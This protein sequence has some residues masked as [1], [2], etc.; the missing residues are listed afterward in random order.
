MEMTEAFKYIEELARNIRD[1]VGDYQ[2]RIEYYFLALLMFANEEPVGMTFKNG[3][4]NQIKRHLEDVCK[5]NLKETEVLL[6]EKIKA[7]DNFLGFTGI[8][9]HMYIAKKY[10]CE[11]YQDEVA[12]FHLLGAILHEPPVYI[13]EFLKKKEDT[14]KLTPEEMQALLELLNRR[15]HK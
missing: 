2:E 3:E 9:R 5:K 10:A 8:A 13:Q 12:S 15:E 6:R 11:S 4:R 14:I 1:C 7:E